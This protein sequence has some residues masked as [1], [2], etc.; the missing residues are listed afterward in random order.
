MSNA[1]R[2]LGWTL[3]SVSSAALL[4][5]AAALALSVTPPPEPV[6]MA[7]DLSVMPA[8]APHVAA[9]ADPAPEVV[10]EIEDQPEPE[11]ETEPP[12]E[13]EADTAPDLPQQMPMMNLPEAE[14]PVVA[15][16][17]LPPPPPEPEPEPEPKPEPK[18]AKAEPKPEKKPEKKVEKKKEPVKAA[19]KPK[20]KTEDKPK[21]KAKEKKAASAGA[22]G[23]KESAKAKGGA[24]MSPAAFHKAVIKKINRTKKKRASD[25]GTVLVVFSIAKDGGL[26]SVRVGQSSG[27]AELD[28]IAVD[29][30]RRSAPFPAP[31][32][33]EGKNLSFKF[34]GK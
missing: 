9:M 12:P 28:Q 26:A 8:S 1:S 24:E 13:L 22:T 25:R 23:A 6:M 14:T 21:E 27:S 31:P 34:T 32:P 7:L 17:S 3:A 33:G 10:Q 20:E 4:S 15:D 30:I 11:P 18:V 29:H 5:G 16:L 2:N 19:E